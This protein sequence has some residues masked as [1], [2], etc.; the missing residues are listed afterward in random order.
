MALIKSK[1]I[2]NLDAIKINENAN[3]RFTSDTNI[4]AINTHMTTQASATV[5]GHIKIGS[6]LAIDGSGV[7]TVTGG[8]SNATTVNDVKYTVSDTQ[9]STP[10]VNDI[11]ITITN[12]S[13]TKWNGTIWAEVLNGG[14]VS[15]GVETKS[16][17]L[18]AQNN[19]NY[20]TPQVRNITLSTS[21]PSG[22]NN[23]DIWIKYIP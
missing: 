13:M 14:S 17:P 18:V 16:R 2:V 10:T 5:L 6:G 19:T 3:K 23:G 4:S 9:P 20:T 22:G 1:Q 7:V 11:W 15:A 12:P 21:D 8:S